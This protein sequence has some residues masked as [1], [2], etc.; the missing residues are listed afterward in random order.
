M[1]EQ[2]RLRTGE[3]QPEPYLQ[4]LLDAATEWILNYCNIDALPDGLRHTAVE[5]AVALHKTAG[6]R[7]AVTSIKEG[8]SQVNYA[9]IP[10]IDAVAGGFAAQLNR[11][12]RMG[13]PCKAR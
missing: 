4:Y 12:R 2:L 8:D 5:M 10:S 13:T 1:L 9:D 6:A 11:Y 7:G 3:G